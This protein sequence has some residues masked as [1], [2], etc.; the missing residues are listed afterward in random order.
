MQKC[1]THFLFIFNK[2]I[3]EMIKIKEP[4]AARPI[5]SYWATE[6]LAEKLKIQI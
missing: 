1:N 5:S 2:K 4:F 3:F 6:L